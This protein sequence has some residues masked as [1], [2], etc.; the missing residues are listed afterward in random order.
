MRVRDCV[1]PARAATLRS[2]YPSLSLLPERVCVCVCVRERGEER[3]RDVSNLSHTK[4]WQTRRNIRAIVLL[5]SSFFP[6]HPYT[7]TPSPGTLEQMRGS[8][9]ACILGTKCSHNDSTYEICWLRL[10]GQFY[11]LYSIKTL[12]A[13]HS[14]LLW[15]SCRCFL[16][17][18]IYS[19]I[20]ILHNYLINIL[21]DCSKQ[22]YN[23]LQNLSDEVL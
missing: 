3:E 16:A 17:L 13:F 8:G 22:E 1:S 14:Y 7:Q 6:D 10:H 21:S 12:K 11:K 18:F 20:R 5:K 2:R 4:F 19:I 15:K 23:E 9:F